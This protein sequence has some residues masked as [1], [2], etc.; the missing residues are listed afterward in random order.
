MRQILNITGLSRVWQH[1]NNRFARRVRFNHLT[2]VFGCMVTVYV[3]G[4]VNHESRVL[5]SIREFDFGTVSRMWVE[6]A[7]II[8]SATIG[9]DVD[10]LY[11]VDIQFDSNS[12]PPF[13]FYECTEIVAIT[14]GPSVERL[15][16]KSFYGLSEVFRIIVLGDELPMT[17]RSDYVFGDSANNICCSG[18]G[19]QI[20]RVYASREAIEHS[21]TDCWEML[22]DAATFKPIL[23]EHPFSVSP[24]K[25]VTFSSANLQ[26]VAGTFTFGKWQGEMFGK[27]EDGGNE[28]APALRSQSQLPIDLFSWGCSGG[29]FNGYRRHY[30][31]Y[32]CVYYS[33][34]SSYAYYYGIV[35]GSQNYSYNLNG[36]G[37]DWGVANWFRSEIVQTG[38]RTLTA[39]EW[40][41]LFSMRTNA[42]A[43]RAKGKIDGVKGLILLPDDWVLPGGASLVTD[44][45]GTTTF[46]SN[47]LTLDAWKVLED[48]GAIFLP[49]TGFRSAVSANSATTTADDYT[50]NGKPTVGDAD[51]ANNPTGSYWS[52]TYSGSQAY[53]FYFAN[54]STTTKSAVDRFKGYG[55][56]LV[57]DN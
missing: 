38:W 19:Q 50:G 53:R 3:K 54:S 47:T 43:R 21:K 9:F 28:T 39:N 56:R 7:E 16:E 51:H 6:G 44:A 52:T 25:T 45:T 26:Y 37:A 2:N 5:S 13:A 8:P 57:R 42:A 48:A 33:G 40:D 46:A 36:T 34:A 14:L 41:Y 27:S 4:D 10:G 31:P 12:V 22:E 23:E 49:A 35:Y 18:Y 17:Q 32:D 15:G 1:M 11:A 29:Q 55:V 20:A 30:M 24:S